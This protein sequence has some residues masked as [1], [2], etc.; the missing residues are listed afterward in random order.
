MYERIGLKVK[1]EVF[2]FPVWMRKVWCPTEKLALEQDWDVS[3]CYNNDQYGHSGAAHLVYPFLDD[4]GIRWI[5][6]DPVYEKMWKDMARTV[7]ENAQ[8]KEMQEMEKYVYDRAYAVFI[9]S[10]LNLYAVNKE[11]NFVPQKFLNLRL[12]ETFVTDNHWS[13]RSKDKAEGSP[14]TQKQ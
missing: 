10:P 2:P 6:Y 11:V 1:L 3:V 13:V 14:G 4:S 7:D 9:Y 12:K 8:D 5:E